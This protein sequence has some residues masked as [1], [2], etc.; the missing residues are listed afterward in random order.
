[1]PSSL[2]VALSILLIPSLACA[3]P[4]LLTDA[5][6][7][8][9]VPRDRTPAA[10]HA[11]SNKA[12]LPAE[13]CGLVG[14][15]VV[16]VLIW[17]ILL[18]TVGRRM[19]RRTENSPK[20]L[21]LELVTAR[22]TSNTPAS[23]QSIRSASSSWFKRSF[24]RGGQDDSVVSSPVSPVVNSPSSFDQKVIEADRERAQAEMERLYAA[25]MEH[26]RKKSYSQVSTD[27]AELKARRPSNI[28]TSREITTNSNPSSPAKAIYPPGY[29]NGP[30]TAPLPRDR[31]RDQPAPAS[32]RSI[33]SKKSHNSTAS[34]SSKTRFNLKNLRISGPI[35][36]YPGESPY[37]EGRTPLSPRF[38]NPGAP[39]S[40]PTQHNSPVTPR[41]SEDAYEQIDAVQPLPRPAP[42]RSGSS[43]HIP[44]PISVPKITTS[45]VSA[46]SSNASLPLRGYAEPMQSPDLR[47]TVLDRRKDKLSLT[48][49]KTGVPFTP[50]SPYMPFT[51]ITPVT[52]HLVTKKERKMMTK[53]GGRKQ[54]RGDD[55]VQTPKEIFGDAY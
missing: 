21:E 35:Q 23:P 18:L 44:P 22:P 34:T 9:P 46:T 38:Y 12:R 29:G 40:P 3:A 7:P 4:Y 13:I 49:P 55:M 14:G 25:V 2:P 53:M 1:M 32:P 24:R 28:S 8:A 15:Y 43:S 33:L 39:P 54:P 19:R 52:P 51:P 17:G 37:D 16:T 45:A 42:H 26:D 5:Q 27:D 10:I 30:T 31:Y 50:Y 11:A 47:T 41:E 6:R 20:T 48:T 36:K